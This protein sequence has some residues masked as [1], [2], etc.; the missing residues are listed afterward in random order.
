MVVPQHRPGCRPGEVESRLT[1]VEALY[2]GDR[3]SWH[4]RSSWNVA[5]LD[6]H[7][8]RHGH[9]SQRGVERLEEQ[10]VEK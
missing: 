7:G 8:V 3:Q 9:L 6:G 10:R 2:F 5:A 1:I 4:G